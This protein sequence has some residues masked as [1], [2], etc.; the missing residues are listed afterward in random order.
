[1][2]LFNMLGAIAFN[3]VWQLLVC[4]SM[5]SWGV[6]MIKL[7]ALFSALR[8]NQW[9]PLIFSSPIEY[10]GLTV[11]FYAHFEPALS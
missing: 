5:E 10:E 9:V 7:A 4:S 6:N 11:L 3:K 2:A 8:S 1:M